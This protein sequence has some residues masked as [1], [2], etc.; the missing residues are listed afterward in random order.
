MILP[1]SEKIPFVL[2]ITGP[3]KHVNGGEPSSRR[4]DQHPLV[5]VGGGNGSEE[6]AA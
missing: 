1:S 2:V 3:N 6:A 4:D 5:E